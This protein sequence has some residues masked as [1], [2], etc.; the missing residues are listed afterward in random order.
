MISSS[1]YYLYGDPDGLS[2][3]EQLHA[4]HHATVAGDVAALRAAYGNDAAFPNVR[5]ECGDVPLSHAIYEGPASLVR[6]LL[7][8]GA[9]PKYH[10]PG[11]FPAI[12][13]VIDRQTPGR[14]EVLELLLAHG[15]DIEQRGFNDWT[16][17][18]FAASRD[19]AAAVKMLL[20]HGADPDARTHIDEYATPLEE[21]ERL[22]RR[23]AAAAL[24]D[25]LNA[26]RAR[27]SR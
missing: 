6:A 11:G 17:L 21:A 4:I 20:D 24:R 8:L 16:A 14:N 25:W 26:R 10:D 19:D 2:P 7:E 3:L 22:G 23:D 5:D 15:A 12:M 13:A 9:D 18:H 1:V 27:T